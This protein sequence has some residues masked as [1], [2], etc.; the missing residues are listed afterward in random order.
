MYPNK[1]SRN[2]VGARKINKIRTKWCYTTR[3]LVTAIRASCSLVQQS[4]TQHHSQCNIAKH[5]KI[6]GSP[7]LHALYYRV[8]MLSG[9]QVQASVGLTAA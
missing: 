3:F 8:L 5:L 2:H 4:I 6:D 7:Q 9:T 1:H